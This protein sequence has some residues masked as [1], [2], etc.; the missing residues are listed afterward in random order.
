MTAK[1]SLAA[2]IG[3]LDQYDPDALPVDAARRVIEQLVT[4]VQAIERVAIRAA[5]DRILANDLLSPIDV[6]AAD[7][8]AM[9]GYAFRGSDLAAQGHTGL[10]VIGEA[11]AGRPFEGT[12]GPG[13]AVRIMTGAVMPAGCDTVLPQEH[14][15]VEQFPKMEGRQMVMMLAPKK[16]K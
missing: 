11:F 2:A 6:P 13:Q 14:A 16:K 7:N 8:A 5:L 3:C 1:G 10:R 9:D 12:P 4:P 15:T